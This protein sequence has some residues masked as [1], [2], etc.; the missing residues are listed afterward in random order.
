MVKAF[1]HPL[2]LEI[3]R[4]LDS[5]ASPTELSRR[6]G[7]PLGSVS[8]HVRVLAELGALQLVDQAPRRGA[9]EH[10]YELTPGLRMALLS[11]ALDAEARAELAREADAFRDRVEQLERESAARSDGESA[12][13]TVML[14]TFPGVTP[15]AG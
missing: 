7:A 2:R 15:E 5:R 4:L 9:I 14:M 8:Y 1:A 3:L 12:E 13:A 6:L 10:Y 11:P